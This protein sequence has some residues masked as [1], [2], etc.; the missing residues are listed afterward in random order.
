MRRGGGVGDD[1]DSGFLVL[2]NGILL[3]DGAQGV[4]REAGKVTDMNHGAEHDGWLIGVKTRRLRGRV[5]SVLISSLG[6][7]DN[8]GGGARNGRCPGA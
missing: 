5:A 8:C 3:R 2:R 4:R 6:R 1:S 7:A